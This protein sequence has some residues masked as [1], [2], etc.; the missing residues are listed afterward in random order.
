[1]GDQIIPVEITVFEDRS[2]TYVLKTPPVSFLIRK[3]AGIPKGAS[4]TGSETVATLSNDQVLEIAK[5]K[6]VD[7]NAHTIESAAQMVRGAARSMG[8]ACS[9]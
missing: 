8:V 3:A 5:A 7:L 6:M 9:Q 4:K 2:F 1:M